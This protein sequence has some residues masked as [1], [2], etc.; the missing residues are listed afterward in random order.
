[1]A[2]ALHN[3][4]ADAVLAASLA[5][6]GT[7][8]RRV[9]AELFR[10]LQHGQPLA[11]FARATKVLE[12]A[13]PGLAALLGETR[14]AALLAGMRR[15]ALR[16]PAIPPQPYQEPT[17]PAAYPQ[18][19]PGRLADV[20]RSL[21]V[22][23]QAEY[24]KALAPATAALVEARLAPP[25]PPRDLL[26]AAGLGP[27]REP[28]RL[29]LID[30]AVRD[31]RSRQLLSRPDFDRLAGQARQKAFTV[32]RVENRQTLA[33]LQEAL[34]KSVEEGEDLRAFRRRAAEA[35]DAG[36]VLAEAHVETVFRTNVQQAYSHGMDELL[37]GD[38]VGGLFPYEETLPIRDTRLTS[39]CKLVSRSGLDGTAVFRRD[40]PWWARLKPPRHYN[41]RCGRNPLTLEQ[42]AAR[43]VREAQLW[44]RTGKPPA[45][46]AFVPAPRFAPDDLRQLEQWLG[47]AAA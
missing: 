7:F 24:L 36:T 15:V 32:A 10:A 28:V 47:E 43:G 31:L 12:R 23:L 18:A 9:R 38:L 5:L 46:P 26:P 13:E 29:P 16:L 39:L 45:V 34:A 44:L 17:P 6:L 1:M 21:P 27:G 22:G 33:K 30:Q 35:L 11:A 19:E 37:Q 8:S 42:A 4:D 14:L 40:D 25:G 2:D 3:A 20:A 41:C